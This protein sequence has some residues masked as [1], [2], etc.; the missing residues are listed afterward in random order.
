[1]SETYTVT[2]SL[3]DSR[4]VA[5]DEA[6]PMASGRVRVVV[7]RL[8]A[9]GRRPY[10]EVMDAIRDRQRLRGHRP[11]SSDSVDAWIRAERESWGE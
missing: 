1:M 5:L 9:E 2:G 4:T 8:A 6:V 11:P 7:E 3:T 10:R